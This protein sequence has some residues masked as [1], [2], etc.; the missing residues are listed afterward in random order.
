M[1]R[2]LKLFH[3][4]TSNSVQL[5]NTLKYVFII[6]V[7]TFSRQPGPKVNSLVVI[8]ETPLV[9]GKLGM[10]TI[11][12]GFVRSETENTHI[13]PLP[14]PITVPASVLWLQRQCC[15]L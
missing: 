8:G 13:F 9:L 6:F 3:G 1:L 12:S 2:G 7:L 4:L 5:V 15:C 10:T 14:A 11:C